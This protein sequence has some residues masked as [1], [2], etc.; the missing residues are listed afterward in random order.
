MKFM[1]PL[2][3]TNSIR[4]FQVLSIVAMILAIAPT[5]QA[6]PKMAQRVAT[7]N[8]PLCFIQLP[9]QTKN[10]DKLCGLGNKGKTA[11]KNGV[12][13]LDIDVNRDGISDQLLDE[14]QQFF[15]S[16]E[17]LDKDYQATST[18]ELSEQRQEDLLRD[19]QAAREARGR[20]YTARLPYSNRVRQLQAEEL[21]VVG[22]LNQLDQSDKQGRKT[23]QAKIMQISQEYTRDPS[24]IK[25]EEAQRKANTEIERRGSAK[26]LFPPGPQG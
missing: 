6:A 4:P 22:R 17:K 9:G 21:R 8:Q 5:A 2:N 19:Y 11:E 24:Y 23:L 25:V 26:W 3:L 10:L 15:D 18:P 7:Q 20:Q 14:T 16:Q 13:N 12:F 1:L